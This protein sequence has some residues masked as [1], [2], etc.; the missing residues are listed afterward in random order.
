M[1]Y[2]QILLLWQN[3][4]FGLL[5]FTSLLE[6]LLLHNSLKKLFS[7]EDGKASEPENF[8]AKP[9]NYC[10]FKLSKNIYISQLLKSKYKN[11]IAFWTGRNSVKPIPVNDG[12]I[13]SSD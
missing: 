11:K 1:Y 6:K 3:I 13:I 8:I 10:M 12:L 5:T 9:C 7:H 2:N 4:V